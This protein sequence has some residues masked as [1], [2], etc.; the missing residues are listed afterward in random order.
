MEE[1]RDVVGW[2]GLYRVSSHGRVLGW[3]RWSERTGILSPLGRTQRYLKVRLYRGDGSK[4]VSRPIHI[5][6]ARAFILNLENKPQ[7]NHK[8]GDKKN[9]HYLN[10]EWCTASENC[11]HRVHVLNIKPIGNKIKRKV[12]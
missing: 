6:V 3:K 7:V 10:L 12:A 8:N 4:W 5:L 9:N 2:E 11:K 1:W